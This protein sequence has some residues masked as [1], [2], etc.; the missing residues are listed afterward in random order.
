MLE[1][2]G[3]DIASPR[4]RDACMNEL[5]YRG[6]STGKVQ[7]ALKL[8]KEAPNDGACNDEINPGKK[9]LTEVLYACLC[10]RISGITYYQFRRDLSNRHNNRSREQLKDVIEANRLMEFFK[11]IAAFR[12]KTNLNP[13]EGDG[14][15]HL[16]DG[17]GERACVC[18]KCERPMP[19]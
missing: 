2:V 3:F 15:Q 17:E 1:E 4:F 13:T 7:R 10:I 19:E 6:K 11:I 9:V 8:W 16:T 12:R 18:F 5:D 14:I